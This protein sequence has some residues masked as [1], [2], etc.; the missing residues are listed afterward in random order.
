MD[1]ASYCSAYMKKID[2]T[3]SS[4]FKKICE[5]SLS[6]NYDATQVIWK[7]GNALLAHQKMSSQ[8]AVHIVLSLPLHHSSWKII[9]INTSPLSKWT[10]ILQKQPLLAQ[11]PDDSEDMMWSSIVDKYLGIA[12]S[13]ENIFLVE[14]V[15][16][17]GWECKKIKRKKP[18]HVIRHIRYNQY[19]DLE[20][21]YKEKLMLFV[22]YQ[23][24]E[25]TLK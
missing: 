3:L 11:E 10:Y 19:I 22:P 4:S 12:T 23:D 21:Y 1:V 15:A 8:Q 17:Y 24:Y 20:N 25:Q 16:C 7:L 18:P 6:N 13:F 5:E 14:Y 9:F 2:Q